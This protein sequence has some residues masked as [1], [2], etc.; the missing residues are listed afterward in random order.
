[1]VMTMIVVVVIMTVIMMLMAVM[2]MMV[3]V[4]ISVTLRALIE[5]PEADGSYQH[6]TEHGQPGKDSIHRDGTRGIE[7]RQAHQ[8]NNS[9]VRGGNDRTEINRVE[10]TSAG[11]HKIRGDDRLTMTRSER[12]R[13]A[14]KKG[15]AQGGSQNQRIVAGAEILFELGSVLELKQSDLN[16]PA[17]SRTAATARSISS[18]VL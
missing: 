16:Q 18:I 3:V 14:K 17:I 11:T 5:K 4:G 13:R 7:A 1:M 15:N 12:V 6:S 2:V 10:N 8:E 9:G